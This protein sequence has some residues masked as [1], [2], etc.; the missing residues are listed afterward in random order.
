M[1]KKKEVPIGE[2][3]CRPRNLKQRCLS[4]VLD[5]AIVETPLSWIY[6][7]IFYFLMS[8]RIKYNDKFAN[9]P[10]WSASAIKTSSL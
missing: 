5:E 3:D 7:P 9:I 8:F 6:P 1:K 10:N 2:L 4:G